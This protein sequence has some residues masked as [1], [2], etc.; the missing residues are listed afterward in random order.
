MLAARM[1]EVL[2]MLMI[3]EGV[4]TLSAP[5]RHLLLWPERCRSPRSADNRR[6]AT[7]CRLASGA[8]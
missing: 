2:A 8:P 4:L 3:G 5:R 6:R 7:A 1:K